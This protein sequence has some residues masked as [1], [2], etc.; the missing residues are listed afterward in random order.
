MSVAGLV[1]AKAESCGFLLVLRRFRAVAQS[2]R[3]CWLLYLAGVC[4]VANPRPF[5]CAAWRAHWKERTPLRTIIFNDGE[6]LR[7]S[8]CDLFANPRK[9]PFDPALHL[10][11]RRRYL[12][13]AADWSG[14]FG[15]LAA[16]ARAG[17]LTAARLAGVRWYVVRAMDIVPGIPEFAPGGGE[18]SPAQADKLRKWRARNAEG[19]ARLVRHDARRPRPAGLSAGPDGTAALLAELRR[20]KAVIGRRFAAFAN[21]RRAIADRHGV[22]F[23]ESGSIRYDLF[24]AEFGE[25][26]TTD[27]NL[28]VDMMALKDEYDLAVLVSGDQDFVPAVAA[29]QR[30][31]RKVVNVSFRRK[32]G[33]LLPNGAWQ[34]NK[35]ADLSV[36]VDYDTFRRFLFPA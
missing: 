31:G 6:N 9:A 25:E 10:F 18:V 32:G 28:A 4:V 7:N 1:P 19:I 23:C 27:V 21:K 11:D 8:I 13:E 22:K 3:P 29:V 36:K 2:E 17:G 24:A 5:F 33:G 12:P 30:L 34:L 14:F 35:A 16:R 15:H 26:K 20:R